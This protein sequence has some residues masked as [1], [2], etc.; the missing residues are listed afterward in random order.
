MNLRKLLS[1]FALASMLLCS[2]IGPAPARAQAPAQT[3]AKPTTGALLDLNS[4]TA[5]QLKA[6]PGVGDA[7][8]QK[9]IAG[10]PYAKKTDLVGRK[11]VPA[12]TYAKFSDKVIAKQPKK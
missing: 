3:A 7:Y 10:R 5:D 4:A 2:P 8:S 1:L 9:I 6:L 12:A 11:I